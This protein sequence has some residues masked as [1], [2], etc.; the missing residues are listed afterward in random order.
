MQAGHAHDRRVIAVFTYSP[1]SRLQQA[2]LRNPCFHRRRRA[3]ALLSNGRSPGC[4]AA[5]ALITK[6]RRKLSGLWRRNHGQK[7]RWWTGG[8]SYRHSEVAWFVWVGLSRAD[9]RTGAS[10]NGLVSGQNYCDH[11]LRPKGGVVLKAPVFGR[12]RRCWSNRSLLCWNSPLSLHSNSSYR[13]RQKNLNRLWPS[14]ALN[15]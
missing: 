7:E 12:W 15:R 2:Q 13:R 8:V 4:E 11:V 14:P 1:K 10:V 3:G 6:L 9:S 5:C